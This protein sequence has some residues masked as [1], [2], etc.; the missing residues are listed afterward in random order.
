MSERD[1][2]VAALLE[3]LGLKAQRKGRELWACCPMHEERTPSWQIR[4]EPGSARHGYHR[5][6]GCHWGG[7]AVGL[8]MAVLDV[9]A[10]EA[11]AIVAGAVLP[12][13]VAVTV[14]AR[15]P[16]SFF[17]FRMPVGVRTEPLERWGKPARE[18]LLR[19][20]VDQAQVDRWGLGWAPFG[21]LAG[22]IVVPVRDERGLPQGYAARSFCDKEPR[23]LEAYGAQ[24]TATLGE[25]LW[26]EEREIV[27]LVEGPFDALAVDRAGFP[28]A[29]ARG[30]RLEGLLAIKLARFGRVVVASDPDAAGDR[31]WQQARAALGRHV[32]LSRAELAGRD[33]AAL[34]EEQGVEALADAIALA[35]FG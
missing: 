8:V 13:P 28:V 21:K 33:P 16:R 14:V 4:D 24:G 9:D 7:G 26:P 17:S 1:I 19:R 18:Y 6:F 30:S 35:A 34:A 15:R 27:V 23:Y 22:R 32:S 25:H 2:D 12:P 20:H 10:K 3:R 11:R 5:C 29:G 31:F